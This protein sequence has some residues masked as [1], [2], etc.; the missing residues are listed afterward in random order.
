MIV[1]FIFLAKYISASTALRLPYLV[2][3]DI[4][5]RWRQ[6]RLC[7]WYISFVDIFTPW[8]D[9]SFISICS[10]YC[11][12]KIDTCFIIPW[13]ICIIVLASITDDISVYFILRSRLLQSCSLVSMWNFAILFH[14]SS[15]SFNIYFS[16]TL[17]TVG[18]VYYYDKIQSQV[19]F[20]L[21]TTRPLI[22]PFVFW[23]KNI[24]ASKAL[25]FPSLVDFNMSVRWKY[26][27]V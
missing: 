3:F 12:S 7:S 5:F 4:S 15:I 10:M 23:V 26:H 14:F 16:R 21:C 18:I 13:W 27:C 19:G 8:S 20:L 2:D 11:W 22:A 9:N 6:Q 1:P 25:Q 24:S 17:F